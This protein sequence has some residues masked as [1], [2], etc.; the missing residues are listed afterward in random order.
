MSRSTVFLRP[1]YWVLLTILSLSL[2]FSGCTPVYDSIFNNALPQTVGT[3][4]VEDLKQ[5]V[6]VKRDDLGVPFIEAGSLEDLAWAMGFVAAC[7]RFSQMEGLR[8][9]SRGRLSEMAGRAALEMDMFMRAMNLNRVAGIIYESASGELRHLLKRYSDG[10][11]AYLDIHEDNL[12]AT[13]KMAGHTPKR[14]EPEDC[15]SVFAMLT[16]SLAQNL[17]EEI[18]ILNLARRV[19]PRK[20]AW[21]MPIYPDEPLP[22][23]EMEKLAGI[24]LSGEAVDLEKITAASRQ[25][26]D[27]GLKATAASNNWVISG[28]RTRSGKPIFANDTHLPLALPSIWMMTHVRCPG[29]E[30]AGIALPGVPGIIA[31]YNGHIA[32]GMT[33]VMAD[34]QDIFLEKIKKKKD[35]LYYLYQ[36]AW[37]K[38]KTRRETIHIKGEK[39]ISLTVYETGHGVL[40]NNILTEEPAHEMVPLPSSEASLGFAVRWAAFTPDKTMNAFFNIMRASSVEEVM[41]SARKV[42]TIPLNLV[43]A[44][45]NDIGWQVTGRY[46][47]REKGRGLCPSPGWTGEYDWQGFL[48]PRQHPSAKNPDNG[49]LGTANHR[50]VGPDFPHTLSSTWYYPDRARRLEQMI[51]AAAPY[52]AKTAKAMQ[53]DVHSPFVSVIKERLLHN[54]GLKK[55]LAEKAEPEQDKPI[56]A[57]LS[58]LANFDGEMTVDSSGAAFCGAFLFCLSGNLFADEM[59]GKDTLAWRSLLDSFL[60]SYSALHDHLTERCRKSPFWDNVNTPETENRE[61]ILAATVIDAVDLLTEECGSHPADWRW[62]DL[63][64]YHW[65]TDASRLAPRMGFFNRLGLNLLSGYLNRGPYPAP[66]DHTTL[67]TAA[68]HPGKDFNVWLIPEMRL[69]A[70]FGK[71]EPLI[72]INSTGQ[73]DNPASPHYGDGI[74]AWLK[75]EYHPFPFQKEN[76]DAQ[77][78]QKLVLTPDS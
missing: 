48:D 58:R 11:N 64:T 76:I 21:L 33:M 60:L 62:G 49:Y 59:G 51:E 18:D 31:G 45:E 67:N 37:K 74:R 43:A 22:F 68:Y 10:V 30:G 41:E 14:W 12:P 6:T 77:Y 56:S 44:D 57:A 71:E 32:S 8:L 50:T 5:P 23:K 42:R 20:T 3:L 53:L 9:L 16:L 15:V 40:L 28:E 13:L 17:H 29:V 55:A 70:D 47:I 52:T 7:D 66:G 78:T 25:I 69:I 24:D 36:G 4:A 34:N 38:A 26:R 1:C 65:K 39:D 75:G 2:L 61:D 19:G 73:S 46:P 35:G 72:G 27:L 54:P 63:H